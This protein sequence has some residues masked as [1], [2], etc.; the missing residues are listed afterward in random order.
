MV[1]KNKD[2]VDWKIQ[3]V[4]I[5]T[6]TDEDGDNDETEDSA[7]SKV[8]PL[9]DFVSEFKQFLGS[10]T[11]KSNFPEDMEH[12]VDKIIKLYDNNKSC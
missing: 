12:C 9:T 3:I 1:I 11:I 7:N 2:Q 5:V 10:G 4:K 8:I 6:T